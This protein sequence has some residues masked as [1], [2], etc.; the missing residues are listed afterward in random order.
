M[1][2][3]TVC[4]GR[5]SVLT[6]IHSTTTTTTTTTTK[7]YLKNALHKKTSKRFTQT[8]IYNVKN[9]HTKINY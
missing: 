5:C 3:S 7:P 9:I 2:M 8:D 6:G 4:V 1:R